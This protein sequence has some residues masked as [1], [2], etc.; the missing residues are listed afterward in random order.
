MSDP[1]SLNQFIG[2]GAAFGGGWLT[3]RLAKKEG[4][5][6]HKFLTPFASVLTGAGSMLVTGEA[7]G[8][9][10]VALGGG[11]QLGMM[12]LLGHGG[13]KQVRAKLTKKL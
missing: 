10:T 1:F 7:G 6:L 3:K 8:D 12:A 13:V 4:G 11:L 9:L 5:I 2:L